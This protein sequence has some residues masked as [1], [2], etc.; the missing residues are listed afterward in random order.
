MNAFTCH[1]PEPGAPNPPDAS[2]AEAITEERRLKH[3][4]RE[5]RNGY[6]I[7]PT[8]DPDLDARLRARWLK[9]YGPY[10]ETT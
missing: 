9:I 7:A 6:D 4:R 10:L 3:V 5:A 1:G 8:G 2:E